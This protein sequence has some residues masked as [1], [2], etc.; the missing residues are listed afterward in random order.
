MTTLASVSDTS[1]SDGSATTSSIVTAPPA[2]T[3]ARQCAVSPPQPHEHVVSVGAAPAIAHVCSTSPTHSALAATQL[4]ASA[5]SGVASTP[6]AGLLS[7]KTCLHPASSTSS[8]T[9][10]TKRSYYARAVVGGTGAWTN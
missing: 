1:C 5:V 10:R 6:C 3:I 4:P 8:T 2:G 7:P 9:R